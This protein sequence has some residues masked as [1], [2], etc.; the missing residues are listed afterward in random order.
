MHA[1]YLL[2]L[3][4]EKRKFPP[5]EELSKTT[6]LHSESE[7]QTLYR[8]SIA[9]SHSFWLDQ[10]QTLSWIKKPTK[11]LEYLWD[12]EKNI[13]QHTWFD[14]GI[15]NV[16][17]NCLDRHPNLDK[18]AILW[19]GDEESES[20]KFT[21]RQL[22][23]EVCQF[24]NVLK[25]MGIKK[26]DRVCIYLP[27]IP[28]LA[29]TVLACAR[30]GAIH[31]VVFAGF[32]A[33]ALVHRI[34][35]SS[36]KLVITANFG[37][38]GGKS[39]PLKQTIDQALLQTP[40]VEK[41]I[42]VKR[43]L[44]KCSMNE[45]RDFWYEMLMKN[46]LK[47]CPAEPMDAED[48][49]FILYTSGSTGKPKGVVHTQAGYLLYTSLTHKYV[50]DY[51]EN[52][53]Y[54]C[55]A[56]FGWITG[57]SYSLYG[58]LCNQA[59]VVMFE[60]IPTYPHIGRFWQI[61]EKCQVTQFYTAPTAIRSLL[62][63]GI[64]VPHQYNLQSLRILGTV[65]E[66]INPEAWIWYYTY[67]G[68]SRCP[69]I[70]TWW[71]TETGGIMLSPL[72]GVS[73]IKPGSANKPFF[74]IEPIILNEDGT[75]CE[76]DE[77]GCLCIKRPWPGMM[78][79]TWGDHQRFIDTY[80]KKFPNIYYT[81]DGCR[82]DHDGDYWLLGRLDD[83]VNISG[84]RI[85]IAEVESALESHPAVAEVAVVPDTHDIKGQSLYAFIILMEGVAE[86]PQLREQLKQQVKKEIG[87]IAIP[88]KMQFVKAL[89]KTRSG[90]IMRRILRKIAENKLDELGDTS[91]L[92]DP[93][94]INDLIKKDTP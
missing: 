26:G 64:S 78:R 2:N 47:H 51:K 19:E 45:G 10:A 34:N 36:C 14:D 42:V 68:N 55:T 43:T 49:L 1:N 91:T 94:I 70:D 16:C 30:I 48:P 89:P 32:S 38:R 20:R 40:S 92:A 52:D 77:G 74:G 37:K 67:I 15:L 59:T 58:P 23:E 31:S 35:D 85:G 71:Q 60:G 65:G 24:A 63:E 66:P 69:V 87:S 88:E 7:Y 8:Q 54:W 29:I 27:M 12:S 57:H 39:I 84:H 5:T 81:G 33:D 90:K 72:P 61:I 83:V 93:S 17:Y 18:I 46:S 21:Y 44:E 13:I 80:F 41:V 53:I 62:R 28:E 73:T 50:F 76:G 82:K 11:T 75:P 25:D 3:L 86:S 9:S 22:L 4:H 56:D 79:T 6:Y